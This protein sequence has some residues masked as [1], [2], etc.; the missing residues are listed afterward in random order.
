MSIASMDVRDTRVKPPRRH[1]KVVAWVDEWTGEDPLTPRER[2]L[3]ARSAPADALGNALARD[4]AFL[5]AI[6][7]VRAGTL[8]SDELAA[9]YVRRDGYGRRVMRFVIEDAAAAPERH[10]HTNPARA[11]IQLRLMN[12]PAKAVWNA[13]FREAAEMLAAIGAGRCM[14]PGCGT[15]LSASSRRRYCGGHEWRATLD[16]E[17]DRE[18]IRAVLRSAGTALGVA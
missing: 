15:R 12:L 2:A 10:G 5:E 3:L 18:A 16:L 13:R 4:E 11:L 1:R 17:R 7:Q 9:R 8:T 14:V 6:D